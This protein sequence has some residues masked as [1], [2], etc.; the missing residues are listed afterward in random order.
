MIVDARR[1]RPTKLEA[2]ICII[3]GG[4]AGITL[5]REL[6]GSACTVLLLE[7]GTRRYD[8]ATQALYRGT[9]GDLIYDNAAMQRRMF[10]GSTTTWAGRCRPLDPIDFEERPWIDASGWPFMRA[11][12]NPFYERARELCGIDLSQQD[13]DEWE[14]SFAARLDVKELAVAML[15]RP[16]PL[17]FAAAYE[18]DL[19][20]AG[21]ISIY[22]NAN[23]VGFEHAGGDLSSISAATLDGYEFSIEAGVAVLAAGGV[24]NAR[25]LLASGLNRSGLVGRYFMDH[26][27]MNAGLLRPGSRR[28]PVELCPGATGHHGLLTMPERRLRA[29]GLGSAA[30][31]FIPRA[32]YRLAPSYASAGFAAV[33]ELRAAAR[34]GE[35][36]RDS[37]ALVSKAARDVHLILDS[38]ARRVR[39]QI[40]NDGS[41]VARVVIEATPNLT[42]RIELANERDPLGLPTARVDWRPA[43]LDYRSLERFNQI[44][45]SELAENGF[46]ELDVRANLWP[47]SISPGG[48]P[49]G[50]TRMH[51]DSRLGVVNENCRLHELSN[52]YVAG[53]SVFPTSGIANPTLTILALAVRLADHLKLVLPTQ[54]R[55]DTKPDG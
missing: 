2:D 42:S 47:D 54:S 34:R 39:D 48:H 43:D 4:A 15:E 20:S 8:P 7:S 30:V 33:A 21:N 53:S 29:E 14:A 55:R 36:G 10:G 26:A 46:G 25:L 45:R 23:V 49:S 6:E 17:N 22:L 16:R 40:K 31:Y 11:D 44:L 51:R 52:L 3:G 19:T 5:A 1:D 50:A 35:L 18:T 28:L 41:L 12:L 37:W 9:S 27:Y 38:F 24:E 13:V 32:A